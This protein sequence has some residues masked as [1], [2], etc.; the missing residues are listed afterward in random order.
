M[1]CSSL[2]H[3]HSNHQI[4]LHVF[5]SHLLPHFANTSNRSSYITDL[6]YLL[7]CLYSQSLP[8]HNPLFLSLSHSPSPLYSI[9]CFFSPLSICAS[10]NNLMLH[11]YSIHLS[12]NLL[13]TLLAVTSHPFQCIYHL[14]TW[15]S[16]NSAW[17]QISPTVCISGVTGTLDPTG[18]IWSKGCK[19]C[20]INLSLE[21]TYVR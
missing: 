6:T 20:S 12:H 16:A 13:N 9:Q 21:S 7:L 19:E 10:S 15:Y 3:S 14:I 17:V 5:L 8:W 2:V 18:G 1:L 11:S 4:S